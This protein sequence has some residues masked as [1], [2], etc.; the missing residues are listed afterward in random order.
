VPVGKDDVPHLDG[1]IIAFDVIETLFI[2]G[3]PAL[4]IENPFREVPF[5]EPVEEIGVGLW[6]LGASMPSFSSDSSSCCTAEKSFI[7]RLRTR[8][9]RAYCL[10]PPSTSY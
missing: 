2:E 4:A 6:V 9:V 1:L 7:A 3:L 8:A 10:S 5:L